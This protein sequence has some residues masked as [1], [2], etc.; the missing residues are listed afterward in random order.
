MHFSEIEITKTFDDGRSTGMTIIIDA[1]RNGWTIRW[2][3]RSTDGHDMKGT[4]QE[5][6]DRAIARAHE[7]FPDIFEI[8]N[9]NAKEASEG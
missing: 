2:A 9:D 4:A 3:D 5:N 1:G 6:M 7:T 8:P